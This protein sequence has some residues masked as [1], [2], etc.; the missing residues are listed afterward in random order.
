M[1]KQHEE[2]RRKVKKEF[3][4]Q[5]KELDRL[6]KVEQE[7]NKMKENYNKLENENAQLKEWVERLLEYCN[8]SKE[9][10]ELLQTQLTVTKSL[11]QMSSIMTKFFPF[12]YT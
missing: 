12:N 8:L 5:L 7:Y 6:K 11:D 10:M 2:I 3:K 9:D 4:E 1:S